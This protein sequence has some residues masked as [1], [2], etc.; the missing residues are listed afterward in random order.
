[1]KAVPR[2]GVLLAILMATYSNAQT[3][4]P[5]AHDIQGEFQ[6]TWESLAGYH[7]PSWFRDAKFGIWAHWTAQC[8]PEQGDW[9]ARQMYQEGSDDYK[10]HVA[11]YGH[12]SKFGF[13]DIDNLWHAEHWDPEKLM[14]LYVKAGAHYF[15]AL[16]NHHDNF[17]CW[18]SKYQPWNSVNIGP[19]R[20]I[21]GTWAKAARKRGLRFGVTVHAARSWDW[22]DVSH[23][24][25]KGGPMAGVPYD[26][27]LTE[28]DGK[29]QWWQGYDPVELYGPAGAARTPEAFANYETKFFNRVM[30][31]VESYHPDLL[32]FDDGEPP[33]SHGLQIAANYYNLNED[34]HKG[35]LQAV[36]TAKDP[37]DR[38]KKAM[39]LDYERGRSNAISPQPWQTDTCIGDWHYRRSLFENHAYKTPDQ[40]IKMLADI[41]SKNGNLLLNIPVRGDGTIDQD[42]IAFLQE[43]AAWMK[44]NSESI[45]STRPWKI[46]GEGPVRVRGGGFSE[47]GENKFTASDFRF[48]TKGN[49]LYAIALGW[50]SDGK[51]VVKTLATGAEG[52]VGTPT[53]VKLLGCSDKL[54]WKQTGDGLEVQA[55][56]QKPCEHAFVLRIKGLDLAKSAP[57]EP[58][59]PKPK[60]IKERAGKYDLSADLAELHGSSIQAETRGGLPNL[61]FWDNG[62]DSASWTVDVQQPGEFVVTAEAASLEDSEVSISAAG[63]SLPCKVTA[64]GAWDAFKAIQVG[65]LRFDKAGVYGIKAVPTNPASWKAINLRSLVLARLTR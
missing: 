5:P 20:D 63:Q 18:N 47:G 62:G 19:H 13:K 17:D 55:P 50:P 64:T 29:G 10:F 31:L 6:P 45:F 28:A 8:V 1:M 12:P 65:T 57:V 2:C 44:V 40:V 3:P 46:S 34:W 32:Y 51:F 23:G 26:G 56:F 7:C 49:T 37:S 53:E 27:V 48:T 15:V 35:D 14:D 4:G 9:Y 60:P 11:H 54:V 38:V 24:A 42:E 41:V 58:A 16:A 52:V 22:F 61:G 43:M 36:L 33:T 39:V 30:D 59:P 25:D 21:V